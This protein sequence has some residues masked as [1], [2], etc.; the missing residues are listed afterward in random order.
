MFVE[1]LIYLKWLGIFL[2]L[3]QVVWLVID[4][5]F[6]HIFVFGCVFSSFHFNSEL[7]YFGDQFCF[8]LPWNRCYAICV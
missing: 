7:I 4:I 3:F 1:F 2:Y 6:R 8:C 5:K